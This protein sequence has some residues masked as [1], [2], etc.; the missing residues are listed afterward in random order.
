MKLSWRIS[1]LLLLLP[2]CGQAFARNN[3]IWQGED[4]RA[5]IYIDSTNLSD[6]AEWVK[7]WT[8]LSFKH[9]QRGGW[10]SERRLFMFSCKDQSLE[11]QQSMFY[12]GYM[13][14]GRFL[15]ARSLSVYGVNDMRLLELDPRTKDKEAF[16][17]AVPEGL[18]IDTFKRLCK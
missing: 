5:D 9:V 3:W 18:F 16:L 8:L 15:Q 1:M 4:E 14:E 7:V 6:S 10:L 2:L 11:W 13:G 17:K 12:E